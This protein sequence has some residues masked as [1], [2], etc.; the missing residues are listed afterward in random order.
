METQF[1]T[2]ALCVVAGGM[3]FIAGIMGYLYRQRD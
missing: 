3:T 2:I 1:Y